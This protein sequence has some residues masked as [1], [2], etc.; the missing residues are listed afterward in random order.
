[1]DISRHTRLTRLLTLH[2]YADEVLADWDIDLD[3]V[4]DH[5][6]LSEV[7]A[8]YGVP[9]AAVLRDLLSSL[10]DEP[11][12]ARRPSADQDWDNDDDDWDDDDAPQDEDQDGAMALWQFGEDRR[13][14]LSLGSA[15]GDLFRARR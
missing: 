8:A 1:M 7:C 6:P 9:V 4:G 11:K 2:P 15:F 12:R 13:P 3:E 14:D 5:W 10:D